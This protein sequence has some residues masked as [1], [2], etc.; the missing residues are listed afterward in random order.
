M[1]IFLS[2]SSRSRDEWYRPVFN[3]DAK[4]VSVCLLNLALT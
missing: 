1:R 4:F 2:R 3:G